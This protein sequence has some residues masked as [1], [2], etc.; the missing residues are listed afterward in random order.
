MQRLCEMTLPRT[1]CDAPR[2]LLI[3]SASLATRASTA[4]K[5]S[6]RLRDLG[7]EL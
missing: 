3:G 4:T 5:R 1:A 2:A 6:T 7:I